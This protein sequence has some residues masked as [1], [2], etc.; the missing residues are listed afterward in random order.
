MPLPDE[1][2]AVEL[3]ARKE[4]AA[5]A[6]TGAGRELGLDVTTYNIIT[7]ADADLSSDFEH[8]T[9]GPVEWDMTYA[10][11]KARA[12]YDATA[13]ELGLRPLDERLLRVMESARMIQLIAYMPIAPQIPG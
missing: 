12:A 11:A 5:A 8:V 4:R 2:S 10:D 7:T 6:A 9:L 3:R 13:A 1:I